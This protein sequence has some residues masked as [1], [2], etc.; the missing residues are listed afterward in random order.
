MPKKEAGQLKKLKRAATKRA[1]ELLIS[2]TRLR[3]NA[4][5]RQ[6]RA[7]E[8]KLDDENFDLVGCIIKTAKGE[9]EFVF[10]ADLT[11]KERMDRIDWAR[12]KLLAR[13]S[14]M[15]KSIDLNVGSNQLAEEL[16]DL[17]KV[18]GELLTQHKKDF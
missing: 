14:P 2:G 12:E 6:R 13:H 16:P 1:D 17:T 10:E 18:M 8:D 11:S 4:N 15:L 3:I 9:S 5:K 7:L